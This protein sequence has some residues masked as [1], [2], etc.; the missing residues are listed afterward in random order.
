MKSFLRASALALTFASISAV[1]MTTTQISLAAKPKV[2]KPGVTP[3]MIPLPQCP[4]TDPNG[5]GIYR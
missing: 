1:S 2:T 5:C 4:P 3:D